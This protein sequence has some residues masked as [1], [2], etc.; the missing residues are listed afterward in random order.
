M[1][2]YTLEIKVHQRRFIEK[3]WLK[4]RIEKTN[5]QHIISYTKFGRF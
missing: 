4:N 5:T 1:P 2:Q 3:F